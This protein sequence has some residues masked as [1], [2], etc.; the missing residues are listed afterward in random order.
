LAEGLAGNSSLLRLHLFESNI[1]NA[2]AMF[3]CKALR[4]SKALQELDLQRNL[5]GPE[6]GNEILACCQ[7]STSLQR[8]CLAFNEVPI[9]V[10]DNISA[11]LAKARI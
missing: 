3:I 6:G 10:Q 9:P 5:I 1:S 2:G 4:S 7:T 8:V 11:L